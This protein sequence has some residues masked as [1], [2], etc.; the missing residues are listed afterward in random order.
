MTTRLRSAQHLSGENASGRPAPI[1]RTGPTDPPWLAT[2]NERLNAPG[3]ERLVEPVV[4]P[5]T[6]LVR[7]EVG[8]ANEIAVLV[9]ARR[10]FAPIQKAVLE[11]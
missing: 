10:G 6:E 2:A 8:E 3:R 1:K 9:Q 11:A 4:D 5:Q 7:L